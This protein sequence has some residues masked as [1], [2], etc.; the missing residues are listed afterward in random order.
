MK[1][2]ALET[3]CET[4][5]IAL[6]CDDVV[7]SKQF[8]SPPAHSA[9]LL[10]GIKALMVESGVALSSLDAIGFGSGP[11]SFTGVR[12]ACSVAQGLALGLD[13]PVISICSLLALAE[14]SGG[15]RVY[16]AVDARMQEI[17]IAAYERKGEEWRECIAPSC[18]SP[19]NAPVPD[20]AGWLGV[21]SA[22]RA[23][24]ALAER[25]KS[26]LTEGVNPDHVPS[27]EAIAR[28]AVDAERIDAALA[29]PLYVR[30]RVA[31][32]VAERLAAG[33][34]A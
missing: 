21:G 10:P 17:Y 31:L 30:D 22:F 2:L 13:L 34:K 15:T 5:S 4:A 20:G 18:V 25:L 1:I 9:T 19:D 14:S 6:L 23:Y 33:G 29:A 3:S 8:V 7:V 16:C 12:L 26:S 27:A 11:G 24:P 32:T 28:L